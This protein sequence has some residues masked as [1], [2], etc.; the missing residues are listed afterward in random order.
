MLTERT[1][2]L[3]ALVVRYFHPNQHNS[4][5]NITS[6]EYG[7]APSSHASSKLCLSLLEAGHE[8]LASLVSGTP[9][10][11][12]SGSTIGA[13][14]INRWITPG[15]KFNIA[16]RAGHYDAACMSLLSARPELQERY[17]DPES[18]GGGGLPHKLSHVSSQCAYGAHVMAATGQ[19]EYARRLADIAGADDIVASLIASAT[20]DIN[21]FC[22]TLDG[23]NPALQ[24]AI[25]HG[26]I[27]N[28]KN[29]NNKFNISSQEHNLKYLFDSN[30]RNSMFTLHNNAKVKNEEIILENI[31]TPSCVDVLAVESQQK[32]YMNQ[33]GGG[34]GAYT[35]FGVLSNDLV[36]DILGLR[37]K[38]EGLVIRNNN[39]SSSSNLGLGAADGHR[40]RLQS[41][42]VTND[43]GSGAGAL[44]P[45]GL[46]CK[47]S[48]WMDDVGRGKEFD[49]LAGYWR[50]SDVV[51]PSEKGFVCSGYPLTAAVFADLSK[52]LSGL[53][54]FCEDSGSQ[55]AR[56]VIEQSTSSVDPGEDHEKV[57]ALNDIVCVCEGGSNTGTSDQ[58]KVAVP[59]GI[60][61]GLRI[62]VGRGGP[63]DIGLCHVDADRSKFTV[64]VMVFNSRGGECNGP[65]YLL[66]R[67]EGAPPVAY[68]SNGIVG[69]GTAMYSLKV[70]SSGTLVFAFGD[71]NNSKQLSNVTTE[72]RTPEGALYNTASMQDI[73]ADEF[74]YM[75]T[76][77]Y[78]SSSN[79]CTS[80]W[81][82]VAV[83]V[84]SS[85]GQ[86]SVTAS[87]SIFLNGSR[88]CKGQLHV[89]DIPEPNITVSTLYAGLNLPY[90][91]RITEL[92]I[93]ADLRSSTELEDQREN[94]LALASKR[95][96]QQL[97]VRGTKELFVA[98]R[99]SFDLDVGGSSSGKIIM[100]DLNANGNGNSSSVVGNEDN[101][102]K[103]KIEGSANIAPVPRPSFLAPPNVSIRK[104][105]GANNNSIGTVVESTAAQVIPVE[106]ATTAITSKGSL[107][108]MPLPA[109]TS[110]AGSTMSAAARARRMS[111]NASAN[112]STG[113]LKLHAPQST[114]RSEDSST[115]EQPPP[116][117]SSNINS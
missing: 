115:T 23:R 15:L 20:V 70:E 96:R 38:P 16:T 99:P 21:A 49:K 27:S 11:T 43:E 93:W 6:S 37:M 12:L 41:G 90:G 85:K 59:A 3:L 9:G 91:W 97:R 54:L 86:G 79:A 92:R 22:D 72:L 114:V 32:A 34:L 28:Y 39:N 105:I 42:N 61:S 50:F 24:Y 8:G 101:S 60:Y 58:Q 73:D 116:S 69:L 45:P 44:L 51:L 111:A 30:R 57:K 25:K 66:R 82:H 26:L 110:A 46:L 95:K 100:P 112:A 108:T 13:Y 1:Q 117:T 81:T 7:A 67:C 84:D 106:N 103:L 63:L 76:V 35:Q 77:Q 31:N 98:I 40:S 104:P 65:C 107:L 71:D 55:G 74:A 29:N 52:N 56:L 33:R 5:S 68:A 88:V 87:V 109:G 14:P 102:Q 4:G 18:Y 36:E 62:C 53:E 75:P 80:S 48:S 83:T 2:V 94:F 17:F 10:D 89:P 78:S 113:G 47:P 19:Y 64:E